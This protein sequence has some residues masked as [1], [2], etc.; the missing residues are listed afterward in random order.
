ML[1]RLSVGSVIYR[2]AVLLL[3]VLL[4]AG[5]MQLH[6]AEGPHRIT[7]IRI[8][9]HKGFTRVVIESDREMPY[10]VFSLAGP[11]R[12]VIDLP[13][14]DSA[15]PQAQQGG[16]LVA[17]LR[18]GLF[19]T[20]VGR[21]VIDTTGPVKAARDFHLPGNGGKP[22]RIVLDLQAVPGGG[23][24]SGKIQSDG[25]A[26][27]VSGL[28]SD[29]R[30]IPAPPPPR[31]ADYKPLVVLDPGHGGPDPGAISRTGAPEKILTLAIARLVR[32][33]LQATGRYRALL[34][35][36]RDIYIP[37]RDRYRMAEEAGAD[38]FISLH[39]DKIGRSNVR[40]ASVYTLSDKASDKEAA[41]LAAKEN[42]S[43][44]IAGMD[45]T[46]YEDVVAIVLLDFEQRATMEQSHVFAESLVDTFEKR[47]ITLLRNPHRFAGFAVLKSP[48]VPSVLV[49]MGYLS[50]RADERLLR[51]K[52]H[53]QKIAAAIAETVKT[54]LSE[55]ERLRRS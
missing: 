33:R 19:R 36:D 22:H 20:G 46:T 49:E 30:T 32:D 51:S 50:N 34:T 23:F 42:R 53:Q 18:Y 7:G 2:L 14:F 48:A 24:Q 54:Y 55:Q 13:E 8:G 17:G 21:I 10:S 52:S 43:D 25:W 1:M 39:A 27:Y 37:L 41:M 28:R 38:L 3:A 31:T 12:L 5:Q 45:L 6:A 9:Q 35:R 40:G 4:P 11:D 15:A 29:D 16:G 44:L 47:G 26:A